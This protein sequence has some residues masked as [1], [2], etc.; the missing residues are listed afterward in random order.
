MKSILVSLI[1]LLHTS[2][3][4]QSS[5]KDYLFKLKT[6]FGD[7]TVLLYEE[8]PL[9]KANFMALAKAGKYDSTYFHRVIEE[10]MIQGGDIYRKPNEQPSNDDERI[11]A[12]IVDALFHRKGELAAARTNNPEKKSSNCQF[13]IV[14]GKVYDEEELSID[15]NKLNQ[16]FGELVTAGQ[17]DSLYQQLVALQEEQKIDEM[18]ILLSKSKNL[19]EKL[20][21]EDLSKG[22]APEV[23][24]A[25]STVGGAPHLDGAYTVFGRVVEG[26]GVIDKIAAVG[27]RNGD[28]PVERVY[29]SVE[30]IEMK[31]KKIS[32]RY[33]YTYPEK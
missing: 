25:Y 32:K 24:K 3:H 28:E 8:T 2:V 30:V 16:V 11:P 19:L 23:I 1:L 9:H 27:T 13:Y 5:K 17:V 18:N 10:F 29:M 26:L 14:Q 22:L 15:Q 7:M 6:S 31:K 4:A 12:E 20:S 33:G 21:G